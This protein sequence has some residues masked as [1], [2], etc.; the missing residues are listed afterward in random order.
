MKQLAFKLT[1]ED[2]KSE[3]FEKLEEQVMAVDFDMSIENDGIGPY[4]CGGRYGYDYGHDYAVV[5][6]WTPL[7]FT[8][9]GGESTEARMDYANAIVDELSSRTV[10]TKGK[11]YKVDDGVEYGDGPKVDVSP[12]IYTTSE[13]DGVLTVGIGWR[14]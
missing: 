12:Y 5:E 7:K 1:S 13:A 6:G 8:V 14:H 9:E 11:S 2:W 3:T 10:V 4:D